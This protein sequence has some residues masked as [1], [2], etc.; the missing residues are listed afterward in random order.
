MMEQEAPS[1][2]HGADNEKGIKKV[3]YK[4]LSN[5]QGMVGLKLSLSYLEDVEVSIV[6][7]LGRAFVK[8]KDV[9][10]MDV[11]TVIK[12]DKAS[13]DSVDLYINNQMFGKGEV[14]VIN[15]TYAL[16]VAGFLPAGSTAQG[17]GNSG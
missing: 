13:G 3:C 17:N 7:E 6:V 14:F 15:D 1:S 9:L 2:L 5:G 8:T 16:K 11:G 4:P 12:L 10:N